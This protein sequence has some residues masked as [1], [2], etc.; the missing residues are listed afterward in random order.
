MLVRVTLV[1]DIGWKRDKAVMKD[2]SIAFTSGRLNCVMGPNGSGKTTMLLT[3]GGALKPIRGRVELFPPSARKIYLPSAPPLLYGFTIGMV[4]SYYTLRHKSLLL[5][6]DE[7]SIKRA[8]ELLKVW[9]VTYGLDHRHD[10]LSSGEA[11]KVVLSAALSSNAE[12][13]FL[14]EPNSHLDVHGRMVLYELLRRE[15]KRRLIVISLHDVNEAS[16]YCDEVLLLGKGSIVGHGSPNDVLSLENLS[17]AYNLDFKLVR[18]DG[19]RL[20]VPLPRQR[21]A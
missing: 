9:N 5:K 4:L 1:G 12:A 17:K 19:F 7:E 11:Q 15:S 13:L 3:L 6:P 18:S 14:D 21:G 10:F 16:L 20:F 8:I 2:T